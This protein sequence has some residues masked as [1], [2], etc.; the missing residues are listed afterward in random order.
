MTETAGR[1]EN[2]ARQILKAVR[3]RIQK[4]TPVTWVSDNIIQFGDNK[5]CGHANWV[6]LCGQC[7]GQP[8][9]RPSLYD[10]ETAYGHY[11]GEDETP[12]ARASRQSQ[13]IL[14]NGHTLSA[15]DTPLWHPGERSLYA[16]V[17]GLHGTG[18]SMAEEI[19]IEDDLKHAF[20]Y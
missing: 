15:D 9:N 5:V 19:E 4:T 8:D 2:D 6:N 3:T 1:T 7:G 11:R 13:E 16:S 18:L 17:K 10:G 14:E 12:E 20:D